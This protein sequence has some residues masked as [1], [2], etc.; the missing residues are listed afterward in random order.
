MTFGVRVSGYRWR[1][2]VHRYSHQK[3]DAG[4]KKLLIVIISVLLAPG[5]S[6]GEPARIYVPN[7]GDTGWQTYTYTGGPKGFTGS[8]GF[9]VSNVK[10]NCAYSELLLD[11][12]SHGG[13]GTNQGF[14]LG[15]LTGYVLASDSSGASFATVS[16]SATAISG[17]TYTP[18][19]GDFLVV[20]QGLSSGVSTSGFRNATGQIGT[21]GSILETAITLAP[22]EKFSFDWAF[23]GNDMIPYN[24][25]ALFYLK[26]PQSGAI[27]FIELLAQIGSPRFPI[28]AILLLLDGGS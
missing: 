19:Q 9:V 22:G 10:D 17:N 6:F 14:E 26:D 21:V 5:L 11:N 18:T 13:G 15:N 7:Y 8:A 20:I 24:D 4:M 28:A 25:F 16:A 2:R 3:G 27:V 12:L 1:K 23:L